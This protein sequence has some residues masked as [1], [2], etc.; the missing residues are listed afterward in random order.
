M[1][2]TC[3]AT[4]CLLACIALLLTYSPAP[5]QIMDDAGKML[6]K[7]LP[8]RQ[9][10]PTGPKL[11]GVLVY[12]PQPI[13]SLEGRSG[14][15]D[16]LCFSYNGLSY[17]WVYVPTDAA[18]PM[19]TNLQVPV[20]QDKNGGQMIFP[21]LNMASPTTV[22]PHGIMTKYTL[23]EIEINNGAGSPANDSF[24][25]TK[26]KSLQGG[27]EFPLNVDNVVAQLKNDYAKYQ[28]D[29]NQQIE[30]ALEKAGKVAL[31]DKKVTGPRAKSD[32]MYITWMNQDNTL[33]VRFLTKITDG[34]FY[35]VQI[36]G[37]GP[38]PFP[39]PV[40][41]KK[42]PPP[43]APNGGAAPAQAGAAQ[44]A[45]PPK[46]NFPPPPPPPFKQTFKVGTSFGVV[47]GQ[48]YTVNKEGKVTKTENIAIDSFT[49][50][51]PVPPGAVGGPGGGLPPQP[52]PPQPVPP[53]KD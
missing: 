28:K 33:Q 49:H 44:P 10:A 32:L 21:K 34:H 4:K 8:Y 7:H 20:G 18:N 53:G 38:G 14:P 12:D 5:A 35:E 50:V 47:Y 36:N 30:A 17:R 19:I 40:P 45:L 15:A 22:A 23:V 6:E 46:A 9:Y 27:K 48:I 39:L 37:G 3:L 26:F 24:V 51:I 11:V 31:K 2:P 43:P 29:Q 42:L 16:E 52:L 13:L 1:K 25:A 41:D